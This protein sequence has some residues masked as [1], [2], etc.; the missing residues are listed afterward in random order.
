MAPV[1][2]AALFWKRSTK[3]GALAATLFTA[4][5]LIYFAVLQNIGHP[6]QVIWQIGQGK[7]AIKLLFINPRGDISFWNGFMTVAPMVVGSALCMITVSLL[8][9]A[10]SPATIAKYFPQPSAVPLSPVAEPA[11]AVGQYVPKAA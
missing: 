7:E 1:M 3:W 4:A 8:T 5:C 6:G 2:I 9:R 10:P 11:P